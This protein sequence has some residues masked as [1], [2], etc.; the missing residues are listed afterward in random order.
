MTA[1]N[2]VEETKEIAVEEESEE[3]EDEAE[4]IT[5]YNILPTLEE[6]IKELLGNEDE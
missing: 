6:G 4:D 3:T 5:V 2:E 1:E